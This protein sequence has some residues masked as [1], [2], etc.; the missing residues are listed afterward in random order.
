M[1]QP[2]QFCSLLCS[3]SVTKGAFLCPD[4]C[5]LHVSLCLYAESAGNIL[6]HFFISAYVIQ[7]FALPGACCHGPAQPCFGGGCACVCW[8]NGILELVWQFAGH[9]RVVTALV[10]P[11]PL[12]YLSALWCSDMSLSACLPAFCRCLR[13][14][15]IS[16]CCMDTGYPQ[17]FWCASLCLQHACLV[18]SMFSSLFSLSMCIQHALSLASFSSCTCF[19]SLCIQH[20]SHVASMIFSISLSIG[21]SSLLSSIVFGLHSPLCLALSS[22]CGP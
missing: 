3:V 14:P 12:C 22:G 16:S 4:T 2:T 10:Y 7:T 8:C 13:M 18:V 9:L 1:C 19:V 21:M 17:G 11:F 5:V 6:L 15:C 20:V